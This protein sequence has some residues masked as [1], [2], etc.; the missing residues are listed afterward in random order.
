LPGTIIHELSHLLIAE[1][2]RVK[3]GELTFTPEVLANNTIRVGALKIAKT[4][5]LRP[6]LI[7]IAP[8]LVGT[9]TITSLA[10]FTL[11]PILQKILFTSFHP[12]HYQTLITHYCLLF[13]VCYLIFAL[14][15]TMFSSKK[16]LETILFPIII[17]V[18]FG[19]AFWL[20]DLKI[21]LSPKIIS[22]F[23]SLLK[24]L[25]LAL[26]GTILIDFIFLG[27]IRVLVSDKISTNK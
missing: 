11:T 2:L 18:V 5:P 9:T 1:L 20:A 12:I 16:D 6:S 15:N 14:S 17:I 27:F 21:S 23:T 7:G 22:S 3:T 10:H 25:N 19:G 26:A 8:I 4:G 13:T 24:N